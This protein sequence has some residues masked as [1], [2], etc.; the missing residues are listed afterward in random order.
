MK[1]P[2]KLIDF[3]KYDPSIEHLPFPP[4]KKD[5]K[6][7]AHSD[8][9]GVAGRYVDIAPQAPYSDTYCAEAPTPDPSQTEPGQPDIRDIDNDAVTDEQLKALSPNPELKE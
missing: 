1:D 2:K 6:N 4:S 7:A 8:E 5:Y 3:P 9:I